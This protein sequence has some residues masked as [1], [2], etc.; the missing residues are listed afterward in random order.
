MKEKKPF[1]LVIFQK[2]GFPLFIYDLRKRE[3]IDN[4]DPKTFLSASCLSLKSNEHNKKKRIRTIKK[5]GEL[6]MV[7]MLKGEE[8]YLDLVFSISEDS[9]PEKIRKNF[10][11]PFSILQKKIKSIHKQT[12]ISNRDLNLISGS[13]YKEKVASN[14]EAFLKEVPY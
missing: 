1:K 4:S 12:G 6:H 9:K 11:K 13:Q 2:I 8:A 7:S 14:I 5:E 3:T 10:S